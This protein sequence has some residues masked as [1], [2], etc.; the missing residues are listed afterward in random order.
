MAI[1][2]EEVL[3]IVEGEM[4]GG[5]MIV[6]VDRKKVSFGRFINGQFT[7]S[8]AGFE[9]IQEFKT[10]EAPVDTPVEQAVEILVEEAAADYPE[11]VVEVKHF[12][13]VDVVVHAE[14]T[15]EDLLG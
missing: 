15:L 8:P 11:G 4:V 9:F 1:G 2:W 3:D 6:T 13:A 10:A 14:P 7:F 12:P 5:E